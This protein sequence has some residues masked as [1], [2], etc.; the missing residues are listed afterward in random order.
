M[1]HHAG[2]DILR[3]TAGVRDAFNRLN[4]GDIGMLHESDR[5]A[6]AHLEEAVESVVHPVHPVEGNQ[7]HPDYLG[8]VFDLLLDVLGADCEMMNSVGQTH[9]VTSVRSVFILCHKRAGSETVALSV[10]SFYFPFL[11]HLCGASAWCAAHL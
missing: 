9:D 4:L 3:G 2:R 1:L 6:V 5:R 7:L 8:E 11:W 10:P